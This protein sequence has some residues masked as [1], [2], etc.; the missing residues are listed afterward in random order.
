M[1]YNPNLVPVWSPEGEGPFE[2][3]RANARDLTN[4][5]GWSYS[6]PEGDA[7]APVAP[8]A[9]DNGS[10]STGESRTGEEGSDAG[11]GTEEGS[12]EEAGEEGEKGEVDFSKAEHFEGMDRE[13]VVAILGQKYPDFKPHHL[14]KVDSLVAKA[15][16]LANA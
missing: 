4:H 8:K 1:S 7:P 9:E 6:P 10:T 3:S 16:E 13:A 2:M 11:N 14:A 12:G 15:V 5:A